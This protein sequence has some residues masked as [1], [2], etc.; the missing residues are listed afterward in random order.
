MKWPII[1]WQVVS[2]SQVVVAV[3][4][5]AT[6]FTLHEDGYV[7]NFSGEDDFMVGSF[8]FGQDGRFYVQPIKGG[9]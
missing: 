8:A 6:C 2:D 4:P 1:G 5:T 7:W 3:F 9:K